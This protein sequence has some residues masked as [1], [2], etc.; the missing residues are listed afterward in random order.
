MNADIISYQVHD[1]R[2]AVSLS[3]IEQVTSSAFLSPVSNQPKSVVG[4]LRLQGRV[5]PIVSMRR[6]L[7]FPER[8]MCLDDRF[9]IVSVAGCKIGMWVDG[10][11]GVVK[12]KNTLDGTEGVTDRRGESSAKIIEMDGKIVEILDLE[13]LLAEEI[14]AWANERNARE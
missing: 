4:I 7:G 6:K 9:L 1:R 5:I 11:E 8:T 12:V 13:T 2:H 14:E 3:H 10:V